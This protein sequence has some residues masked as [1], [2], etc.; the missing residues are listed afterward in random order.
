M[1]R[2]KDCKS[3]V[4]SSYC[5][6]ECEPGNDIRVRTMNAANIFQVGLA[7]RLPPPMAST[8]AQAKSSLKPLQRKVCH[9]EHYYFYMIQLPLPARSN[10]LTFCHN[11]PFGALLN[12]LSL[13]LLTRRRS[14]RKRLVRKFLLVSFNKVV[15][16]DSHEKLP[17][18]KYK[19]CM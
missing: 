16:E 7:L 6:L 8:S 4:Q 14:A 17:E 12:P 10:L 19:V 13:L 18:C 1:Y 2:D 11:N 5:R 15:K 3:V 9:S